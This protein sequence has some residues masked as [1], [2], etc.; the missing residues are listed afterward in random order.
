MGDFFNNLLVRSFKPATAVQPLDAPPLSPV[1]DALDRLAPVT[2]EE[3]TDPFA[4]PAVST[5]EPGEPQPR[6]LHSPRDEQQLRR[7]A[8]VDKA[9]SEPPPVI[10]THTVAAVHPAVESKTELQPATPS[11]RDVSH[12]AD[13]PLPRSKPFAPSNDVRPLS[14]EALRSSGEAPPEPL[15][16]TLATTADKAKGKESLLPAASESTERISAPTV[17]ASAERPEVRPRKKVSAAEEVSPPNPLRPSSAAPLQL[18]PPEPERRQV[19]VEQ[20]VEPFEKQQSTRAPLSAL[21]PKPGQ[22]RARTVV[23]AQTNIMKQDGPEMVAADVSRPETIINVTIGRI[24]VRA[25]PAQPSKPERRPSAPQV[26]S[27]DDYLRKRSGG[28][29]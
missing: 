24:E 21:I 11:G 12:T 2:L 14:G 19:V 9:P 5:E 29:L 17:I 26:M 15:R 22:E 23:K 27:L 18:S 13:R 8:T 6:S 20:I 4:D 7:P 3:F 25:T 10:S 1:T 16:P 28:N